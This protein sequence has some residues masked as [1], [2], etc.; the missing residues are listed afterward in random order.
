MLSQKEKDILGVRKAFQSAATEDMFH[1]IHRTDVQKFEFDP[2]ALRQRMREELFW[3]VNDLCMK[4]FDGS[5]S[6]SLFD[7][8]LFGTLEGREPTHLLGVAARGGCLKTATD[9]MDRYDCDLSE[10]AVKGRILTA[11]KRGHTNV[12]LEMI[13]RFDCARV[14]AFLAHVAQIAGQCGY[15]DATQMLRTA[16]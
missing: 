15:T 13:G 14:P 3:N 2:K 5:A 8:H 11:A 6:D 4:G 16:V 7:L 9:L 1:K 10:S 12:A